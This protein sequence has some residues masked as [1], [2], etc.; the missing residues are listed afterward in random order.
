[1]A[2]PVSAALNIYNASTLYGRYWGAVEYMPNLH[3]ELCYYQAQAFCIAQNIRFF[4]G[5]A[6]E[7]KLARGFEPRPTCSYHHIAHPEFAN[8]IAA[9]VRQESGRMSAYTSE[10]E[11]RV[12]FK[13]SAMRST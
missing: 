12:P 7:H 3:F 2:K 8:A 13:K 10:L 9:F 11:E 1:M 4:E 5:G 6:G